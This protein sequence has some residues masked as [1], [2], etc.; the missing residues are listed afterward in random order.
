[1]IRENKLKYLISSIL[2]LLPFLVTLLIEENV[3]GNMRGAISFTLIMPVVLF[4]LH[5]VLLILTRRIDPVKQSPKVEN[6]IFFLMPA[7]SFYT[8]AIFISLML[9]Y[10]INISMICGIVM[11]VMFI[12]TGNYMPKAKRNCTYG[13][14]IKWTLINDDNWAATHR[15][16]GKMFMIAGVIMLVAAF[17]PAT[18]MFI[19]LTA[20]LLVIVP[21]P[22][23]YSYKFYK[24]QITSGEATEEDYAYDDKKMQ[25]TKTAVIIISV[26][27][28]V[29][30]CL[31][32]F[33][34]GL[35]YEFTDD[36]LEIKPTMGKGIE[37][38][39]SELKD[40]VIE[41]RE[42]KVPGTRV[43][44]YGSAK[45]L[46]GQFSND[47][48]GMYTRYTYTASASAIV[49]R[50]G[51]SVIVISCKTTAQTEELYEELVSRINTSI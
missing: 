27:T 10:N 46:Y 28:V 13:I 18:V 24:N 48:F 45:L 49:I 35:K 23:I 33:T 42:E 34:G 1:M 4:V 47:E 30:V 16:A 43:I 15:L 39:Y 17:L 6:V 14:K 36:Y 50:D 19:T 26:I 31:L 2:I 22:I 5:T 51:E 3:K 20:I 21:V 32:M 7:I 8:G 41:Y 40:A 11:G 9:G 25:K 29:I 37:L 44:G 38:E 12:V